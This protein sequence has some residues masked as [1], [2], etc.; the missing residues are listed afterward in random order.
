MTM[1]EGIQDNLDQHGKR[2]VVCGDGLSHT[3]GY[4]DS[5]GECKDMHKKWLAE[6]QHKDQDIYAGLSCEGEY[7]SQGIALP[8]FYVREV[9]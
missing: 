9:L 6:T 8:A 2:Y 7:L 1:S 5:F 3:L 4:A